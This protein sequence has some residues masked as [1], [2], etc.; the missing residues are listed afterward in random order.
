[1]DSYFT[2]KSNDKKMDIEFWYHKPLYFL[3]REYVQLI[4]GKTLVS[5][6]YL[7]YYCQLKKYE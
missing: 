3:H 7:D 2:Y 1:M 6:I 5:Q 4:E